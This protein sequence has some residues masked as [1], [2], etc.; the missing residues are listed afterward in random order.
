MEATPQTDAP[1]I[2]LVG[3]MLRVFY[4]PGETFASLARTHTKADWWVPVALSAI[5]AVV[6]AQQVMPIATNGIP[7][8]T[9]QQASDARR[10]G[11]RSATSAVSNGSTNPA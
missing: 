10:P 4:A 9:P 3:R 7:A 5:M 6:V 2:G 11:S 1:E 8:T